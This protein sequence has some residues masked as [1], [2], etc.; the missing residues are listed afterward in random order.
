MSTKKPTKR[1]SKATIST[2]DGMGGPTSTADAQIQAM[3]VAE[4]LAEKH[5]M[6]FG[7]FNFSPETKAS[8]NDLDRG[9]Q[10][11]THNSRPLL[12][13]HVSALS[14]KLQT[15]LKFE[16]ESAALNIPVRQKWLASALLANVQANKKVQWGTDTLPQLPEVKFKWSEIKSG[17]LKPLS[18]QVRASSICSLIFR[19]K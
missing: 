9:L 11:G 10:F 18:G 13:S 7:V 19:R 12:A 6:G 2:N 1:K 17:Q 4:D 3:K 5:F 15:K 14:V 16:G 8:T